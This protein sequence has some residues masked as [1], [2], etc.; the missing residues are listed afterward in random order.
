VKK[1]IKI[2]LG[3]PY[4]FKQKN[5]TGIFFI[6]HF[7]NTLLYIKLMFSFMAIEIIE[8]VIVGLLS[9]ANNEIGKQ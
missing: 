6:L 9:L 3:W 1:Y 8:I 4:F 7:V 2:F 5:H